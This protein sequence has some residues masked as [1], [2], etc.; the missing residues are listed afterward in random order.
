MKALI[1]AKVTDNSLIKL[2]KLMEITYEPW[3]ETGIIYF[4]VNELIEKLKDYLTNL[5]LLRCIL[6]LQKYFLGI[7]KA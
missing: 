5:S 6:Y 1:T 4:D 7:R 2:E 3:R